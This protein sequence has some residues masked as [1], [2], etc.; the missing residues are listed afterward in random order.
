MEIMEKLKL[1]K[2]NTANI[3]SLLIV[4]NSL[5]SFYFIFKEEVFLAFLFIIIC[6]FLDTIDGYIARKMKIESSM[7]QAIDSFCDLIVYLMFPVFFIFNYLNFNLFVT[8]FICSI[9]LI[10]GI[11]KL[12][13]FSKEGF[14]IINNEK[15]YRGLVVPFVLLTTAIFYILNINNFIYINILFPLAVILI[16]I[17]MVSNLKFKKISNFAWYAL[18]ILLLWMIY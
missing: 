15:Y 8:F 4:P 5:I 1:L 13:R 14:V 12:A 6:F 7:G 11:I 2:N 17:L 9:V 16:S 10:S 3:I 18:A